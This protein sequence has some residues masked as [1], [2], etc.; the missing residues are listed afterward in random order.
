MNVTLAGLRRSVSDWVRKHAEKGILLLVRRSSRGQEDNEGSQA[1]QLNQTRHFARYGIA[2][3]PCQVLDRIESAKEGREREVVEGMIRQMKE[4]TLGLIVAGFGSR[5]TRSEIDGARLISAAHTH[6][7]LF[8]VKGEILDPRDQHQHARLMELIINA[9]LENAERQYLVA[10]T[11]YELA[12]EGKYRLQLPTG[13]FWVAAGDQRYSELLAHTDFAGWASEEALRRH[14]VQPSRAGVVYYALPDPYPDV[15]RACS[16]L[17]RWM[18]ETRDPREVLERVRHD[19]AYP[20]RGLLPW[21]PTSEFASAVEAEWKP[22]KARGLWVWFHSWGLYGAYHFI[23]KVLRSFGEE[24]EDVHV[25][26]AFPSLLRPEDRSEVLELIRDARREYLANGYEGPRNYALPR[27][28]CSHP[29]PAGTACGKRLYPTYQKNVGFRY[30]GWPKAHEGHTKQVPAEVEKVVLGIVCEA[31]DPESM[32]Y[33]IATLR[34]GGTDTGARRAELRGEIDDLDARIRISVRNQDEAE[35]GKDE[36]ARKEYRER[37]KDLTARRSRCRA[38]LATLDRDA[39]RHRELAAADYEKMRALAR[40]VPALLG[41]A[42]AIEEGEEARWGET[43]IFDFS[44]TG[45]VRQIVGT[46]VREVRVRQIARGAYHVE[47]VFRN[48]A[49]ARRGCFAK[50][51]KCSQPELAWIAH[52]HAEGVPDAE[53]AAEINAAPGR[54]YGREQLA[55]WTADRVRLA[56]VRMMYGEA[57]AAAPEGKYR[58][59]ADLATL[60][61]APEDAIRGLGFMGRLGPA[62]VEGGELR[63]RSSLLDLDRWLPEYARARIARRRRWD[64]DDVA[65]VR[66]DHA[67]T[68]CSRTT[69]RIHAAAGTFPSSRDSAGRLYARVSDMRRVDIALDEALA[70]APEEYRVL[71]RSRW[72]RAVQ[73]QE[74]F[75]GTSKPTLRKYCRRVHQGRTAWYYVDEAVE[76]AFARPTAEEA[77]TALGDEKLRVQDF[78]TVVGLTDELQ[79]RFSRGCFSNVTE[80]VRNSPVHK[81]VGWR[82]ATPRPYDSV[83]VYVPAHVLAAGYD[84]VT[85]WL[86]GSPLTVNEG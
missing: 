61:G 13:F 47:V 40:D 11:G 80:L 57:S 77:V 22:A 6:G 86:R 20:R 70:N 30:M 41:A 26:D 36:D 44:R 4:G 68:A 84:A 3:L 38:E 31:F 58:T 15:F 73:I 37:V 2:D 65:E 25:E 34:R 48:G 32:E 18:I 9:R 16:L 74:R 83:H 10:S 43:G 42:R 7:A 55:P 51:L 39:S 78:Y 12:R 23:P 24:H 69:L 62:R 64:I 59:V 67:G 81:V 49:I 56:L 79:R 52:R 14:K 75:P 76:R 21:Q 85:A 63:F 27:V 82:A 33:A 50:P 8:M 19:P 17:A 29:D 28:V 45:L 35:L 54:G 53:I 71:D 46:L 66:D 72:L 60:T 1:L 5:I